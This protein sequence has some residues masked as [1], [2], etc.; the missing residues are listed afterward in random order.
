MFIHLYIKVGLPEP[1][2]RE[3]FPE[4]FEKA[5]EKVAPA[6]AAAV[7]SL[8]EG[9]NLAN[10]PAGIEA[11]LLCYY[12]G[13]YLWLTLMRELLPSWPLRLQSQICHGST[14]KQT[15]QSTKGSLKP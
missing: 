2:L 12:V 6:A 1:V 5:A 8:P 10:L 13:D 15:N 3:T 14:G 4:L 11:S 7:S 9:I